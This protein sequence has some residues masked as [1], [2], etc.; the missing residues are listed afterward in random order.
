MLGNRTYDVLPPQVIT[1][2][3]AGRSYLDRL[4]TTVTRF[5]DET[6]G[7]L[8]LHAYSSWLADNADSSLLLLFLDWFPWIFSRLGRRLF[9][10]STL[11][12]APKLNAVSAQ[13]DP[14]DPNILYILDA[15]PAKDGKPAKRIFRFDVAARSFRTFIDFS[16]IVPDNLFLDGLTMSADG[17]V[18]AVLGKLT[19]DA[20]V[21][22]GVWS[23]DRAFSRADKFPG[24][25]PTPIHAA[26]VAR[27]GDMIAV[28]AS[29]PTPDIA[30]WRPTDGNSIYY[31][32]ADPDG[33][34]QHLHLGNTGIVGG[35]AYDN[36]VVFR[37]YFGPGFGPGCFP[38]LKFVL[39]D[40]RVNWNGYHTSLVGAGES[41]VIISTYGGARDAFGRNEIIQA[42]IRGRWFRRLADTGSEVADGDYESQPRA[43]A[44]RD[45]SGVVLTSNGGQPGR[46]D[47][48]LMDLPPDDDVLQLR[49]ERALLMERA[50]RDLA[51]A[52]ASNHALADQLAAARAERDTARTAVDDLRARMIA[53]IAALGV[54]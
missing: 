26:S 4:G 31:R 49:E 9:C 17:A 40:G 46:T 12:G 52:E 44:L 34:V 24:Q 53:G 14:F 41:S 10:I 25:L 20:K 22:E 54:P 37:P 2:P 30:L 16:G 6:M 50:Q 48:C 38:L 43:T 8:C 1:R 5:T 7:R 21:A 23:W 19:Q 33:W 13:W 36:R 27:R 47:V 51:N 39:P 29:N 18:F 35:W 15:T 45:G 3:P 11:P 28:Y 32:S 42:D